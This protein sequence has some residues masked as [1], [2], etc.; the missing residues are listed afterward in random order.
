[1]PKVYM[2][3][4]ARATA[5]RF[6]L[7]GATPIVPMQAVLLQFPRPQATDEL[8]IPSASLSLMVAPAYC[9]GSCSRPAAGRGRS[10]SNL[11]S[12]SAISSGEASIGGSATALARF[13]MS[14]GLLSDEHR[15]RVDRADASLHAASRCQAQARVTLCRVAR[16]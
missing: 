5:L 12:A 2:V 16:E 13:D 8:E 14:F 4:D 6:E 10:G 1:M 9:E 3:N 11:K 15:N 7:D